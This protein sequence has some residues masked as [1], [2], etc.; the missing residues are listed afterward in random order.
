MIVLLTLACAKPGLPRADLVV[1]A[2]RV[3]VEVADEESERS[4]GLMYRKSMSADDGMLF[5]Y[6]DALERRFWMKNTRIPLS[7]AF[8]DADGVVVSIADMKPMDTNTTPSGAPAM[9]A[10]EMNQGWFR[11]HGV[12]V[13]DH[14][15]GLPTAPGPR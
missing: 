5:V 4:V 12:Q 8:L 10:L 7:I 11:E 1:G 14:V 6:P 2:E 13:G 15:Q 9:Y 3:R